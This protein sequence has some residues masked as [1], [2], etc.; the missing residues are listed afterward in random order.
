MKIIRLTDKNSP[1]FLSVL[2]WNY[3]WWGVPQGKSEA[4]VKCQME[5]SLCTGDKLPQTF[6]AIDGEEPVGVYQLSMVDD[7]AGRPDIYPWLINVFVP[8]EHR[9]KNICRE[10]M[11][12]VKE[13]AK[14]AGIKELYLYTSHVGLYEKFGWEFVEFVDTFKENSKKER[15]YK[16]KIE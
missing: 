12:S 5:H 1:E 11:N 4:E 6:V 7:L 3:N 15:L 13:N 9:G 8:N 16:L 10:M 2:E 14:K